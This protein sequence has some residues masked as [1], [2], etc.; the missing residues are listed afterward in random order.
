MTDREN[1]KEI[2]KIAGI[3]RAKKIK[4]LGLKIYCNRQE[5]IKKA[6]QRAKKYMG[7][8]RGKL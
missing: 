4:Y 6:K 1:M 2:N 3:K 7:M 8:I 5:M